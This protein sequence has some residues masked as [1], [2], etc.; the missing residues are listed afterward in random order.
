MNQKKAIL[1][2][3]FGTTYAAARQNAI[4]SVV[5]KIKQAFPEF[6]TRLAFT[7]E[8]V[9]RRLWERDS[10]NV[11]NPLEALEALKT[12][13]VKHVVIQPLHIIPG[14]EWKK[15]LRAIRRYHDSFERV[16]LGRPLLYF[17]KTE[18]S[19]DD[20][21]EAALALLPQLPQT[22][23][24]Q[25]VILM[26]H[27]SWDPA[28]GCYFCFEWTLRKLGAD[29]V[30]LATVE[31]C[32]D[33]YQVVDQLDQKS[34]KKVTLMPFMLVAGEH[35]F[36]DMAGDDESSWKS[37][38]ERHGYRVQVWTHGL[39]EVEAFQNLF[40]KR[41]AEAVSGNYEDLMELEL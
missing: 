7:A 8:M 30:H 4:D 21:E 38:L 40:V 36:R 26:A 6:E 23:E 37:V 9:I 33:L 17:A 11:E 14:L 24:G 16:S 20:Y 10:I 35:V 32:P 13:G 1:V 39:G 31:G 18:K 12:E 3:A 15:L 29:R 19:P 41:V 22:G 28:N 27:G 34:V 5:T 2:A 25:A